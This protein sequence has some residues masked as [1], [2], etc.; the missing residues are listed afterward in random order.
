[1]KVNLLPSIYKFNKKRV[2]EPYSPAKWEKSAQ[3]NIKFTFRLAGPQ[4]Y[5]IVTE[6]LKFNRFGTFANDVE[7]CEF[8]DKNAKKRF[9]LEN[10][11]LQ[12]RIDIF[13]A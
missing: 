6:K 3:V 2:T 4:N 8:I 11:S 10:F 12:S 1:V 5:I 9:T 13:I 7:E